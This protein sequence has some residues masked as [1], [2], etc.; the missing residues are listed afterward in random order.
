MARVFALSIHADYACRHS[1]AC[2][3]AGWPI[4]VEPHALAV[5]GTPYLYPD[6]NGACPQFDAAARLC[7][8]QRDHGESL[9]P[10]SCDQFPRRTLVDRRGLFVTLSHFCPTA[11]SQ[12][13]REDVPLRIVAD[14]SGFP[15]QRRYDPLDARDTWPPLVKPDLLFDSESYARWEEFVVAVFDR[16]AD[17]ESALAIVADAA[18]RLRAWTPAAGPFAASAGHRLDGS[19]ADAARSC[20]L[21]R[22]THLRDAAAYAR[23]VDCVPEGLTR[24]SLVEDLDARLKGLAE[25]GGLVRWSAPIRR[26]LAAKAF[27]S[28]TAFQGR[29]LRT[30]VAELVVAELVVRVEAARE[31]ARAGARA[32]MAPRAEGAL[33]PPAVDEPLDQ[34]NMLEAFREADRLLAHL[35]D[36]ETLLRWLAHVEA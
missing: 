16:V 32:P 6:V 3:T 33:A 26:Y 31:L 36:R 25:S 35:V 34:A 13:F 18:E 30:I 20:S 22:Y 29:G 2:C 11:A 28:W 19:E 1:G 27:A 21:A 10:V 9:L 14:P 15:P 5:V 8:I 24:P 17:V 23:V 12:L 4:A 7:R